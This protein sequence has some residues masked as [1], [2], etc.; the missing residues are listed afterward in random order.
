M[1]GQTISHYRILRKLGGGGM[2]VVYEAED[3]TLGRHVA[4]KFL[5][6][7][8]PGDAN[9]MERLRREAR[10]AASLNHPNI[11][12]IHEVG[13]AGGRQFIVME[14]MEGQALN[15]RIQ[16]RPLPLADLLDCGIQIASALEAAHAKGII[17][18]D[19]K[20]ANIFVTARGE[21]K[22]LDFGLA[23]LRPEGDG[24]A[25]AT[26]A[27]GDQLT[28]PGTAPGTLAYMSPE[29]VRGEELDA[30]T[31]IFSF[32]LVL[33]EMATGR[34][35]FAGNTTGVITD[36]ILNRAPIPAGRVNA[37]VPP[38]LEETINKALEKDRK[39]RYQTA[40]DLRADL[41]RLKRD[42]D[43]AHG[44]TGSAVVPSAAARPWWRGRV[45]LGAC[46]AAL[47]A[48]LA[49]GI[50]YGKFRTRGEAIDSLA[51][52]PFA[53]M[54][55]NPDTDYLSDGIAESLIDSLSQLPG[56]KVTSWSGVSRYKGRN[57]DPRA[58]GRELNV[59]A[60]LAGRIV[61]R[62][63]K[64]SISAELVEV[65]DNSHL[66]GEQYNRALA[67]ALPVQQEIAHQIAQKL[68]LR[69]DNQQMAQMTKHQTGNPE[70][71][72]LYLK[73]RFYASKGTREGTEKGIDYL[74]QAVA[75]DPNY[76]LPYA[77][78]AFSYNWAS[79]W[80]LPPIE[81]MPKAKEAA[82][83]AAELDDTLA[84]AH[85]ELG[86][87]AAWYDY[88][89]PLAEREF[90]RALELGPNYAAAHEFYSVFLMMVGRIDEGLEEARR[91]EALDSV[92]P[93]ISYI[94]GYDLYLTRRYAQA[95]TQLR[96]SLDLDSGYWP[97]YYPL[98]PA[99]EQEGRFSEAIATLKVARA[100]EDASLVLQAELVRAYALS[101]RRT[102]AQQEL[103]EL[104]SRAKRSHVSGYILA[105][106]YTALG[107]KAQAFAQLERAHQ[108]RSF[109]LAL[110]K[111]D[112]ELDS[113][114]SDPRFVDVLRRMN[115]PVIAGSSSVTGMSR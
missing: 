53:N 48:V 20:P 36:G 94:L 7:N 12:V 114:R 77:G 3:L 54:G 34:Q 83:R 79:D 87:V 74:H 111:V 8:L 2:G 78:I 75:L 42:S 59:R 52:L 31:D 67:D 45:A 70:A 17:H 73:G 101:G 82:R 27:A 55:G 9:A 49:L 90:K 85:I 100:I 4:L 58:V 102:E 57:A 14:L 5:P 107:D 84:E 44:A 96:K 72:Q 43:S 103:L 81:A 61:Q 46:G 21:T 39:L 1:I 113:L 35:A 25:T 95:I 98:V 62:G 60:V 115:F 41:Q 37:Q 11:C 33:Y 13:E 24:S 26:A 6:E 32:G 93:E 89:W 71:Y 23:K 104:L 56:L 22:I 88:D 105:T 63:D 64:L 38:K 68:R 51:V 112:P 92:S 106:V 97:A 19:I 76:A 10:A 66:W 50:W 28:K 109:F 29:Q 99:L 86:N 91:A 15:Q 110:I 16:D 47:A 108:Q 80:L 69:L 65:D 30:R 18:R 40:S